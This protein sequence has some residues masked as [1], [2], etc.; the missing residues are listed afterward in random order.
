MCDMVEDLNYEFNYNMFVIR[1]MMSSLRH[2]DRKKVVCWMNKLDSCNHSIDE[3]RIRNGFM[4]SLTENVQKGKLK[5]PFT[6]DPP[7]EPL[8]DM[9]QQIVQTER[10]FISQQSLDSGSFLDAQPNVRCGAFC[11]LAVLSKTT[12][13]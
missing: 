4:Y 6:E 8:S 10:P 11:Y 2:E 7:Q 1:T 13:G 9:D 5:P 3:M 12:E